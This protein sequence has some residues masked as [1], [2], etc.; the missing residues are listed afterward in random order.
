[1]KLMA[2]GVA[3]LLAL[4]TSAALS[5]DVTTPVQPA[6][7]FVWTGGYVGVQAGHAWG[8]STYDVDITAA[9]IPYNPDGW[10]G[11]IFAGY[12]YQI[13]NGVVVGVEGDI[14]FAGI[15]SGRKGGLNPGQTPSAF[16]NA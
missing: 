14:N 3:W 6:D 9:F 2:L 15:E 10:F 7:R 8:T 16:G 5:A 12:N 4:S 11:G 1:M 13:S